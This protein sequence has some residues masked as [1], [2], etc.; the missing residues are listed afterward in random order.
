MAGTDRNH[1]L[2]EYVRDRFREYGLD[3]VNFH[4]FPGAP[5]FPRSAALAIRTPVA[6]TLDLREDPYPADKD[7]RLYDEPGQVAFH[8][9]APSGKV[10]AEVD[11]CQRRKPRGLPGHSIAWASISRA[12]SC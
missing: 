4:E 2:A 7:S 1:A 6:Q 10:R 5:Q 3:E 9:Y 11:L 8:G 12:R